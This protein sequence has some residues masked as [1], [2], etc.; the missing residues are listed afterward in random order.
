MPC[1]LL[2]RCF[3]RRSD[4]DLLR[5]AEVYAISAAIHFLFSQLTRPDLKACREGACVRRCS[6]SRSHFDLMIR[7]RLPVPPYGTE[8]LLGYREYCSAS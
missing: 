6:S 5:E 1:G 4:H 8:H 3:L 2:L 7:L